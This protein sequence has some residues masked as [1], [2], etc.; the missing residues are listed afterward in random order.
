LEPFLL[1]FGA[2]PTGVPGAA[3]QVAVSLK[4]LPSE[5]PV[6][7]PE[8]VLVEVRHSKTE[9]CEIVSNKRAPGQ[10]K[11]S[12]A[13]A[14]KT[15]PGHAT[16][17]DF[18]AAP[19]KQGA[20]TSKAAN[21]ARSV[22][23]PAKE[24]SALSLGAL[25]TSKA[26]P[27]GNVSSAWTMEEQLTYNDDP[28]FEAALR[29]E[30]ALDM[31]APDD[32]AAA[33]KASKG[34]A[35]EKRR[36]G[37]QRARKDAAASATAVTSKEPE[38][39][40]ADIAAHGMREAQA[41]LECD[42]GARNTHVEG[43]GSRNVHL[44]GLTLTVE[45]DQGTSELLKSA[46]LHMSAGHI[47]GLV[48]RNGSGKTTL[49]RRLALRQLPGLPGHLRFAY[50]AQE[51]AVLSRWEAQT[52]IEAV[53]DAD[54]ERS[55][56][57]QER[58]KLDAL[59][60]DA[61]QLKDV[62][63]ITE[64][65]KKAV[66]YAEIER[67]LEAIE[68]DSAED[69]ARDVLIRLGF[70]AAR[71]RSPLSRLSGGW[72]MRVALAQALTCRPDVLLLDEPTNHLDLHGVLWLQ[73]H[74]HREWGAGAKKKDRIA[75]CVSHDR[76]FLDA[77]VT[78]ILEINCL[79]LRTMRGNFSD[80]VE[81]VTDEQRLL[82]VSMAEAERQE[83]QDKKALQDMKKSAKKHGDEKKF[84][85]LKAKQ[86]NMERSDE[87]RRVKL[88]SQREQFRGDGPSVIDDLLTKLREDNSLRFRFPAID[89]MVSENLLEF[90]GASVRRGK[91]VILQKLTLTL[92]AQ[93]RV[94]IV[95]CN[96]SGKSTLIK[97]IAGELKAEEGPR[98]R[99]RRH[100]A[101]DCGY[102]TQDHL[103]NQCQTLRS[104][105]TDY[106]RDLLPDES[107]VRNA[108]MTKQSEDCH[109][110][111]HLGNFG[112]GKD[113]LKKV[114]YLSGGQRARLSMATS[115]WWH[116]NVLLLDEPTNHLDMDSLDALTMGLQMFEGAVVVVSHNRTFLE[117]LCDELWIVEAGSVKRCPKGEE[118]FAEYFKQYAKGVEASFRS[119]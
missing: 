119:K 11:P 65:E 116:P 100:A 15:S 114:G 18:C 23:D 109:L 25:W 58:D 42:T 79:K 49:L 113:A 48:G 55:A 71:L 107:K 16:L 12:I 67:Q 5:Q 77:C 82:S 47:Y 90:D 45:S 14:A 81:R 86:Q 91:E 63:A 38:E 10:T 28:E 26:D 70:D 24:A 50:V 75:V 112:L 6:A 69:R 9:E 60:A 51:L 44:E 64:A 84:R 20:A 66:R 33:D 13:P 105:C 46:D 54:E 89:T 115:T 99:G 74:L 62:A 39:N 2:E 95:G 97:A 98:G 73:D 52:A 35:G 43:A 40:L 37:G 57:L 87:L 110:R 118:A 106:L 31:V 7:R 103:E 104:S 96:G 8:P 80:Y 36:Q 92:D 76:S 94:A 4:G 108:P 88:S 72:R 61:H 101:F 34:G 68:A 85:Q 59:L 83:K 21:G 29:R 78:D 102:V 30:E 32:H 111:A 27:H 22:A 93:S 41:T 3:M 19:T 1:A 53:V 17:A 117:A 56:L